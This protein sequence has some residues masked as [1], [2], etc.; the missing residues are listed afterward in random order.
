MGVRNMM[1]NVFFD[2]NI[3]KYFEGNKYLIAAVNYSRKSKQLSKKQMQKDNLISHATFRRAELTN[4]VGHSDLLHTLAKYFRIPIEFDI[5]MINELNDNF[6]RLYTSLYYNELEKMEYYYQLIEAKRSLYENTVLNSV[7]HFA[8]LIY[9]VSSPKRVEIDVI[10]ESIEI[11]KL[12]RDDL[13][14]IFDFLFDEYLYCFYSLI[15]DATN[16]LKLSKKIYLAVHKYQKLIPLVLYQMSVNYYFINDYANSIFYSLEALPLLESDLNYKRAVSCY[17]NNAI[18]FERLDN[19]IKC[20]EILEKVFLYLNFNSNSH[21][22]Y[23]A[24]LTLANCNVTDGNYLEAIDI[25]SELESGRQWRGENTLMILYCYYK[26][27]DKESF[28]NLANVV[29][30]EYENKNFFEG[31]NDLVNLLEEMFFKNKKR[32][33]D[34]YLIA[35]KSFPSYSDSKIVDIIN[36]EVKSR[37]IIP[38]LK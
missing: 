20:K 6:N 34:K 37:K 30:E 4:F 2:F 3:Q 16:S 17:I 24:K 21:V 36:K 32:I 1:K 27:N 13:L 33:Y 12:Y 23:L 9:Y 22:E 26:L 18:C 5:N 10:L 19:T 15:H 8:R 14:E 11:L 38:E 29:H 28:M 7:F 35:K 31:Y 25:F